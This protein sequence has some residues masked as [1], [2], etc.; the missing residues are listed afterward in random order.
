MKKTLLIIVAFQQALFI[1]M[2]Q[3][4]RV[5]SYVRSGQTAVLD[6]NWSADNY[7][8]VQWQQSADGGATWTDISGATGTA[9]SFKTAETALY[10]AHIE[11]DPSCPAADLERE[12]VPLSFTVT[13]SNITQNSVDMEATGIDVPGA[14]ITE[15]GYAENFNALGRTY[16]KMQLTK[17]GAGMPDD[18][19]ISITCTGLRH[20]QQYSMRFYFKTG[21]GS[22]VF[23]AGKLVNT[24][25]GI[26]W[27]SEDWTIGQTELR[28]RFALAG[29]ATVA[30][31]AV[32]YGTSA[33]DMT[34]VSCSDEGDGQ[35]LTQLI[36]GLTPATTYLLKATATVDGEQQT[37]VKEIRTLTD[38][39]T[40]TVDETVTP[41][42]HQISWGTTRTLTKISGDT[43]SATEYPRICRLANN[44]LLLT[45]HGGTIS[46][47]WINSYY[48]ISHDDGATWD[49]QVLLFDKSKTF[50]GS[51]Y[52]RICNPQATVLDN[53]YV[54]VSAVANGNPET[55]ENCKVICCISKDNCRT[56]SDPII[57][58]RGRTWEPHVA[59][60]P[61]GELELFVSSEADWWTGSGAS[62]QQ[63]LFARSTDYGRSW[64]TW[65]R[66]A[67]LS[68]GRD[69]M[70]VPIVMQGNKGVLFSIESPSTGVPP[71]FVHR[72]LNGEWDQTAWNRTDSDNRWAT[73]LNSGAGAPYCIQLTTGEIVVTAH[74]NQAGSVWQTSRPQV[75]LTDNTGHNAKYKTL[76]CVT[77]N[78][79]ASNEGAYYNSL[80]QK[81][82]E[83]VWLL[84][85]RVTYNGS[86]RGESTIEY[87]EGTI[88]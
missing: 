38:Y 55:N 9:Y 22:V 44:D 30:D 48:R 27:S 18:G 37:I 10:R 43:M 51:S 59:Q 1:S 46:D 28:G 73:S 19:T 35:Y 78:P 62:D 65:Q 7:G 5:T 39:S 67:Y 82:D 25:A 70:P 72:D 11:G 63:I 86:T 49:D 58:G 36:E 13:V 47:Y 34:P 68:G 4:D 40:Y 84:V 50:L 23:S 15:Y 66:A 71:S 20:N 85:T 26:E 33:D 79:L 42:S 16:D 41:V 6:L 80:W 57:V 32:S 61:G 45:Y 17:T 24:K 31:A 60:L 54:I 3:T 81:D 69:G 56:W 12:I 8:T 75:C 74:T 77:G 14:E 21:D 76:P 83:H 52:Y 64:T 88:Q 87:I 2:A 29:T 53:G